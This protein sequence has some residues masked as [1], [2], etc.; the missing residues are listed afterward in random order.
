MLENKWRGVDAVIDQVCIHT[1][2][3]NQMPK[4]KK[5][6]IS[7]VWRGQSARI[8]GV[9]VVRA[10]AHWDTPWWVE[11]RYGKSGVQKRKKPRLWSSWLSLKLAVTGAF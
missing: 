11:P 1:C 9:V 7:L 10:L 5:R 3:G 8:G 4:L 6:A 2:R